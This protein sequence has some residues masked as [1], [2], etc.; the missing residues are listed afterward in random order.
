MAKVAP[1]RAFHRKPTLGSATWLDIEPRC[2][3]PPSDSGVVSPEKGGTMNAVDV[4]TITLLVALLVID[5][6]VR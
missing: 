5:R 1:A 6:L 3:S 2:T 4:L